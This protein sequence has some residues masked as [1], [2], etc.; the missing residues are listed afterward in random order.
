MTGRTHWPYPL[1]PVSQE[2]AG[3]LPSP[4][5]VCSRCDA[6][7]FLPSVEAHMAWHLEQEPILRIWRTLRAAVA[8]LRRL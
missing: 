4:F 5:G 8:R 3:Y 2:L 7:V 1:H 6:V